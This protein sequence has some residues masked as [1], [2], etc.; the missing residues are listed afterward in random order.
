MQHT[1]AQFGKHL[2]ERNLNKLDADLHISSL[3]GER[4][5]MLS[6]PLATEPEG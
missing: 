5:F 1:E 4:R 2:S 3:R 6:E